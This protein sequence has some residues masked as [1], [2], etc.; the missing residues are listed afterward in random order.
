M[1]R[2]RILSRIAHLDRIIAEIS[3]Q[4]EKTNTPIIALN[5][6]RNIQIFKQQLYDLRNQTAIPASD[7][8]SL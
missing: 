6:E 7:G 5:C 8:S 4:K 1:A 3:E 2:D